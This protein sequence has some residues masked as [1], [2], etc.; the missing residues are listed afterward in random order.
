MLADIQLSQRAGDQNHN[1]N[2]T[3]GNDDNY[4]EENLFPYHQ[5]EDHNNEA[6]DQEEEAKEETKTDDVQEPNPHPLPPHHNNSGNDAN[7]N[8]SGNDTASN[9]D[10]EADNANPDAIE[11]LHKKPAA[12]PF[13]VP[14][15]KYK[16]NK[17]KNSEAASWAVDL[18]NNETSFKEVIKTLTPQDKFQ[19]KLIS[20]RKAMQGISLAFDKAT[21][22][23][24]RIHDNKDFV[25]KCVDIHPTYQVPFGA[26]QNYPDT[27]YPIY[28]Q[29]NAALANKAANFRKETTELIHKGHRTVC[30]QF[31]LDRVHLLFTHL[32]SELG[33]YHAAW[34]RA[35]ELST[36]TANDKALSDEEITITGVH[37]LLSL[38]D[39]EMLAYLDINRSQLIELFEQRFQVPQFDTLTTID[40]TAAE[41]VTK[42]I[43]SYIKIVTCNHFKGKLQRAKLTAAK[44]LVTAK[45]DNAKAKGAMAAT[46]AAIKNQQLPTNSKILNDA[47]S[48]VVEQKLAERKRPNTK[49]ASHN[50]KRARLP[51]AEAVDKTQLRTAYKGTNKKNKNNGKTPRPPKGQ[52]PPNSRRKDNSTC[53]R[54]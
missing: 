28:E 22:S 27:L 24:N 32:V 26:E 35:S 10:N 9:P 6:N 40:Q 51:K 23:Y 42:T 46:D 7:D 41:Y 53:N 33:Q 13:Y 44:A 34:I 5:A 3:A 43:L 21:R 36:T 8:S 45:M 47:I 1:D 12:D 17:N 20:L 48:E 15:A 30:F 16:F 49:P 39:L 2:D 25:H 37:S 52:R 54:K 50:A 4:S 11:D 18:L 19:P 29:I 38:L 31:R 14:D